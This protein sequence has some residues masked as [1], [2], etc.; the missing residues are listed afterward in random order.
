[1][2]DFFFIDSDFFF[3]Y[4][5]AECVFDDHIVNDDYVIVVYIFMHRSMCFNIHK[6]TFVFTLMVVLIMHRP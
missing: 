3:L 5:I 2:D 6:I 1:M 4:N